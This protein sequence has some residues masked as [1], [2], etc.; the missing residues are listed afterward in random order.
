MGSA[1]A[2]SL[3]PADA[4]PLEAPFPP[5]PTLPHLDGAALRSW[6]PG[7]PCAA[8]INSEHASWLAVSLGQ[9]PSP[10]PNMPPINGGNGLTTALTG[11]TGG[12][13]VAGAQHAARSVTRLCS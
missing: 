7:A 8:D 1:H 9:A 4:G 11:E 13:K 2:P 5:G 10:G 12:H 6:T 3:P